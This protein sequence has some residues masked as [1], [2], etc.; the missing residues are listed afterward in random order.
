VLVYICH[1]S[2]SFFSSQSLVRGVKACLATTLY[3]F[4][5]QVAL[6]L[7][8]SCSNKSWPPLLA[9][10]LFTSIK[11]RP[12][13]NEAFH[14]SICPVI[15]PWMASLQPMWLRF[16]C[17]RRNSHI[18]QQHFIFFDETS[19]TSNKKNPV[20]P[21][22]RNFKKEL[23]EHSPYFLLEKKEEFARF[24]QWV[25]VAR[26]DLGRIAEKTLLSA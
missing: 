23:P 12:G 19:P 14:P 2:L 3:N 11:G 25:P 9:R 4:C 26:L 7:L 18:I 21:L 24:R 16:C 6:K 22:G 20:R 10:T 8:I 5:V 17:T 1:P 15:Y 13:Q